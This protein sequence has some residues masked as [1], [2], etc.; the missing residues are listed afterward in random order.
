M[1]HILLNIMY[2]PVCI[3][4]IL[5]VL[6]QTGKRADLAGAFGGGGSQ[7]AFGARGAANLLT[8]LTTG[9]AVLF[10]LCALG[11]AIMTSGGPGSGGSVLDDV[12][13]GAPP[14]AEAPGEIPQLPPA[15]AEEGTPLTEEGTALTDTPED[16]PAAA[17]TEAEPEVD[18]AAEEPASEGS[19]P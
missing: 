12:P 4:L 7:T 3:F 11:L 6:L 16:P 13:G 18:L 17:E 14:P 10:M 15:A 8:K 1:L 5:V 19:E 2:V 9:A